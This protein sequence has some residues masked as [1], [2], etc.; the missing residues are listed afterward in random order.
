MTASD[1]PSFL[2]ARWDEAEQRAVAATPGPWTVERRDGW[3]DGTLWVLPDIERWRGMT[4]TVQFGQD[5]ETA[6][7][8]AANDPA[9][10]LADIAAKRQ[11][12][13]N[14]IAWDN[15]QGLN[16]TGTVARHFA[17]PYSGHPDWR[18]EWEA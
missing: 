12:L 15:Q 3:N 10:V 11:V 6:E 18:T 1:L 16:T 13:D 8:I 14:A 17:A 9:F 4:N 2:R 7:H 5:R